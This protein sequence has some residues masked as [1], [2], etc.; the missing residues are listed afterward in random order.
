MDS[1][2]FTLITS[3]DCFLLPSCRC[4]TH[5]SRFYSPC[6]L[7]SMMLTKY[8]LG[9]SKPSYMDCEIWSKGLLW[10]QQEAIIDH[11]EFPNIRISCSIHGLTRHTPIDW[12]S[13]NSKSASFR[14]GEPPL[15]APWVSLP[16]NERTDGKTE[17]Q[18]L[19]PSNTTAENVTSHRGWYVATSMASMGNEGWNKS[20][21]QI[22][23][24]L[25][26]KIILSY[27]EVL[28]VMFLRR[29]T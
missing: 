3:N 5:L 28:F 4:F 1:N 12:T 6:K 14:R 11:E 19:H 16:T 27:Y 2:E 24:F 22:S 21:F 9:P 20:K 23:S 13:K 29:R 26:S 17:K 18:F 10:W 25:T 15:L 7:V 8:A